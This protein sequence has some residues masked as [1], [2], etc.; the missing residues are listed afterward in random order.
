MINDPLRASDLR[1]HNQNIVLSIIYSAKSHGISQSEVVQKTGLKAPTIFR[2]FSSLEE[3]GFILPIISEVE[4]VGTVKKG[5]RPVSYVVCKDAK[6]SIGLEFWSSYLAIGMFDF[7]GERIFSTVKNLNKGISADDI[8]ELIIESVES[9]IH[10]VG[11]PKSKILGI[12]VAAPG[13]V[14]LDRNVVVYYAPIHGMKNYPIVQ[15]LQERLKLDIVLHNNCSA[16]ALCEYRYGGF[17]H[18]GSM[19]TFLLRSG[20]NGA[21]VH[22]GIIYTNSKGMT[23]ET[24]HIPINFDGPRCS[25][26][27]RGCLQAFIQDLDY[28][29]VQSGEVLFKDLEK[30]L[31]E[32]DPLAMRI[33]ERA[34]GYLVIAM[35][36]IMKFF[37]PHAFLFL[38]YSEEVAKAISM[39][40]QRLIVEPDAFEPKKPIIFATA[41]DPF[42][43]P[44]GASD[45]VINKFF[46]LR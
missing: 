26:G 19:F 17:N 10:E 28:D 42:L 25:C 33:I 27:S 24:G 7:F 3:D 44:K 31:A 12:G 40:V 32:N 16:L 4:E 18:N 1:A 45:L 13:Q 41:Y 39:E 14:D 46:N 30:R 36:T 8:T 22:D 15:I 29:S 11:I 2:I 34:A 37:S 43:A 35:K 5:R 21:F 6:Y 20:V 23:I 9:I 38:V